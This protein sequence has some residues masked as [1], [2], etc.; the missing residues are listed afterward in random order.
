MAVFMTAVIESSS[1]SS[2]Y[3][4]PVGLDDLDLTVLDG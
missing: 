1:H 3:L 2:C 4:D